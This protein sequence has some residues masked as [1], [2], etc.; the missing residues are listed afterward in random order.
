MAVSPS[1]AQSE[2]VTGSFMSRDEFMK[3]YEAFPDDTSFELIEGIVQMA[4]PVHSGHQRCEKI[5]SRIL[6]RFELETPGIE[7]LCEQTL[8]LGDDTTLEPD[9]LARVLP[10]FGGKCLDTPDGFLSGPPELVIEVS[11]SSL[12]NDLNRKRRVY[13][14]FG[15]REYLVFDLADHVCR[16]FD[17]TTSTE[18][19]I[20]IDHICRLKSMPGCWLAID[21]IFNDDFRQSIPVIQAGL[22]SPEHRAFVEELARRRVSSRTP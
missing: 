12:T 2:L 5:L 20:D 3:A 17:L 7:Y 16:W 13:A 14:R 4:S 15:V 9:L 11:G 1:V 18:L 21:A 8:H 19:E 22:A 6:D 10:H